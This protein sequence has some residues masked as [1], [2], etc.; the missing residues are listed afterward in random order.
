VS[1]VKGQNYQL[2]F[3]MDI[4]HLW[5]ILSAKAICVSWISNLECTM[6]VVRFVLCHN[7][8]KSRCALIIAVLCALFIY[9]LYYAAIVCTVYL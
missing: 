3:L 1:Y 4:V 7:T 9:W 6:C 8:C 5:Y 2:T